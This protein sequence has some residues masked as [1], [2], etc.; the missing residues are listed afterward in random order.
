MIARRR[1]LAG[2][3]AFASAAAL[4]RDAGALGR[5]PQG[6]R[7]AMHVPWPTVAI[8]PHDLRDPTAA[9][10][11]AAIADPVFAIEGGVVTATLAAATPSREGADTIVRLREGLRTARGV[12]LDARDL[13]ASI[14][15]ARARGAAAVLAQVPRA[16]VHPKDPLAVVFGP[17]DPQFLAR[18]LASPLCALLPRRFD[19]GA[20]DGTGAFRADIAAAGISLTRNLLA[21]RGASFL[22]EIV[23]APAGDLKTSLRCFEAET[24][25]VGWLGLGLH[26][27][28][29]GAVRMDLG[30]AAWIVLGTGPE[31]GPFGLPGAAQRLVDALPPERLAHL[32]LGAL[33]AASGDPAWGGPPADLLVDDASPHLIEIARAVAP[34]LSRPG[35]EVTALPLARAEIARRRARGKATLA[36]EVVRAVGPTPLH[37]LFALATAEDGSRGRDLGRAPPRGTT[38]GAARQLTGDLRVGVLGEL[39]IAGGAVADIVFARAPGGEG[40]D[41]GASFRRAA[42]RTSS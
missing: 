29:A 12:A 39:R 22:D 41:L 24:D 6:G 2:L 4:G 16:V 19:P 10:F 35:H 14:E 17:I 13:V 33:P 25:D 27:D 32:G 5:T 3:A 30:R 9:L 37:T 42:R 15:R 18:A 38:V 11:A 34:I 28:R 40:W 26:N 7:I 31:A 20:P 8:D 1:V 23:I 36:I 21:A